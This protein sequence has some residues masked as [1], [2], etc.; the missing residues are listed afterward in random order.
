[1]NADWASVV[2]MTVRKITKVEKRVRSFMITNLSG[3]WEKF[4]NWLFF[5]QVATQ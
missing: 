5:P 3:V 4:P 1:M 2:E